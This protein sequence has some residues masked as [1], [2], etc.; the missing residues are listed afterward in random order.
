MLTGKPDFTNLIFYY[1]SDTAAYAGQFTKARELT[2]R[3]TDMTLRAGQKEITAEFEAEAAVREAMVGNLALA[4][5][6]AQRA[7]AISNGRDAT[8]LSAMALAIA[9]DLRG[10]HLVD[11][12]GTRFPEDTILK[13]NL[14]PSVRA[15]AALH[16]RDA[17]KALAALAS[18]PYEL[19]QTVQEATFVLYPAYLRGEA[20]LASKQG[21]AAAG[22]FQKII[23]HPGLVVNEPIGALAHLELGRAYML[24]HDSAEAKAE[25]QKFLSLWKDADPDIP[26]LNQAKAEYA[27]MR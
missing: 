17:S 5:T 6:Q 14:L 24:S 3:M 20:Y 7:L 10:S 26:I 23:D 27:K 9:G 1:R 8:A 16:D 15:S 18:L 2:R 21:A 11:D 13:Y 4:K 12:L 25:Y 19:G 22:E